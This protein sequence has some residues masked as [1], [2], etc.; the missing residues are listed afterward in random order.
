M[1]NWQISKKLLF[2]EVES[3]KE[4]VLA[5]LNLRKKGLLYFLGMIFFVIIN[6]SS[7]FAIDPNLPDTARNSLLSEIYFTIMSE[8]NDTGISPNSYLSN[9]VSTHYLNLIS[10][11]FSIIK[12]IVYFVLLFSIAECLGQA[13][14]GK[15]KP[16]SR[17]K[18]IILFLL[19]MS[20]AKESKIEVENADGYKGSIAFYQYFAFKVLGKSILDIEKE[21]ESNQNQLVDIPSV[22][23]ADPYE[24]EQ[25]FLKVTKAYLLHKSRSYDDENYNLNVI[26]KDGEYIVT[27]FMG[28]SSNTIKIQSNPVLIGY[29]NKLDIAL[30]IKEKKMVEDYVKA[31]FRHAELVNKNVS[32]Y[33]EVFEN[34]KSSDFTDSENILNKKDLFPKPVNEYCEAIY[35][36]N[37][38]GTGLLDFNMYLKLSSMCASKSFLESQYTNNYYSAVDVYS[39]NSLNNRNV[40]V[41]GNNNTEILYDEL[42][43]AST[44]ICA[45]SG[46]L[47]CIEAVQI[48]ARENNENYKRMGILVPFLK[49]INISF[50]S[51][52][53]Y[54]NMLFE[55]RSFK[56]QYVPMP[57]FS[58]NSNS[59]GNVVFN[60]KIK[61]HN[62]DHQG[63]IVPLLMLLDLNKMRIPTAE[64]VADSALS[65]SI[66]E[67][68]ERARTCFKYA[69]MIKNNLKCNTQSKEFTDLSSELIKMGW[70]IKAANTFNSSVNNSNGF[71]AG[72]AKKL[73][74]NAVKKISKLIAPLMVNNSFKGSNYSQNPTVSNVIMTM[75]ILTSFGSEL[76]QIL[77]P[78]ATVFLIVGYLGHY[79]VIGVKAQLTIRILKDFY[80]LLIFI[81]LLPASI[82]VAVRNHG[83]DGFEKIG[84][85]FVARIL[86]I[87]VVGSVTMNCGTT[88]DLLLS[89]YIDH[90]YEIIESL[91]SFNDV[92]TN[93]FT[94]C[95]YMI[96]IAIFLKGAVGTFL[97]VNDTMF[98]QFFIHGETH[99][100]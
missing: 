53:D 96:A 51:Y 43:S 6:V 49:S 86:K 46:Y 74:S 90:I 15:V 4:V 18:M 52:F 40:M 22:Q 39:G 23:L 37:L 19:L 89:I 17:N 10:N 48:T 36:V 75:L 97:Y 87:I 42:L 9:D 1:N 92:I 93:I 27:F 83:L 21:L 13:M 31:L 32:N 72:Q 80:L 20:F 67:P 94:F 79:L 82:F 77:A 16:E 69:R 98:D 12:N 3:S 84:R 65:R 85:E 91:N 61:N 78:V 59:S 76:L 29:A 30:L 33:I 34:L 11:I 55:S 71:V 7:S 47:P 8:A 63:K 45:D 56:Q 2:H 100:Q 5:S 64:E 35:D 68:F 88:V 24:F 50:S 70:I 54:T 57:Y 95:A 81:A 60:V 66:V 38:A 26:F 44:S 28:G 58:D 25:D 99:E 62:D 73:S 14:S 41:F